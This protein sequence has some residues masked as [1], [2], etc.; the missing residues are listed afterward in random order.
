[1]HRFFFI[2]FVCLLIT[3][4]YVSILLNM[5]FVLF[6]ALQ[7][8]SHRPFWCFLRCKKLPD[9]H[10]GTS[11][12]ARSSPT[13]V[14]AFPSLQERSRRLFWRFHRCKKLLD[15]RFGTSIAA[16]SSPTT[17]LVFSA[18]QK[19]LKWPILLFLQSDY[20]LYYRLIKK[21]IR[22]KKNSCDWGL[23]NR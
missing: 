19:E 14:L 16:R 6:S 7:K 8:A 12:A 15:D 11:I 20:F 23:A 4:F 13:T 10:F 9:D 21:R 18:L 22:S 17:V 5:S 3:L 1:M 2:S